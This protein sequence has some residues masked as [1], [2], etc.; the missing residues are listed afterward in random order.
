MPVMFDTPAA[1]AAIV[2]MT[3]EFRRDNKLSRLTTNPQLTAAA[4]A[5]ARTLADRAEL[6]HTANGTTLE[7]RTVKVG[8]SS[9]QLAENLAMLMDSG[10]FSAR[11]YAKQAMQGWENSPGHRK[12]M[13][14]PHLTEIGVAVA[15]APARHPT[16]VAVQVFG[17]PMSLKYEFKVRNAAG[18][19]IPYDFDGSR[20]DIEPRYTVTHTACMPGTV[21]FVAGARYEARNGDVFTLKPREGGGVTVEVG[22]QLEQAN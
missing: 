7:S 19:T 14:L 2:E 12:N 20:H 17:R 9:C 15:R 8:Y 1:E 5:Y 21:S 13:L 3:N 4:K 22:A 6:S 11:D 16:Y 18:R 10:G